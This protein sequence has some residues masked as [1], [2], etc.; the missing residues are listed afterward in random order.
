MI[1]VKTGKY[2]S[3][4]FVQDNNKGY[5]FQVDR[6][7]KMKKVVINFPNNFCYQHAG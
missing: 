7:N 4:A 1:D 3:L 2:N 5:L 6:Q